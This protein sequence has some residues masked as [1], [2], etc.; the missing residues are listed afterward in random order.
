MSVDRFLEIERRGG[1]AIR[2]HSGRIIDLLD[3]DPSV[4]S[5]D[6][7]A[8]HLAGIN[9]WTGASRFSVAQHSVHVYRL[10]GEVW[11]LLHDVEEAIVGDVSSPLKALL[12]ER[13]HEI[14]LGWR[15]AVST[16]FAVSI[17]DVSD[18]DEYSA[19]QEAIAMWGD[20]HWPDRVGWPDGPRLEP[21]D[22]REAGLEWLCTASALGLG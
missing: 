9:R 5:L 7:V 20:C 4:L 15:D 11:G 12:G 1:K 8:W 3:P 13:Y 22:P 18:A 21:Q 14:A 6:D 10:S 16:R 19:R 17:V 2:L